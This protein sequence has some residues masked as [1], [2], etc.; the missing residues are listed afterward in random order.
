MPIKEGRG[1]KTHLARQR[2]HGRRHVAP[3]SHSLT[4]TDTDVS[5]RALISVLASPPPSSLCYSS[6]PYNP[7]ALSPPLRL[8]LPLTTAACRRR[9]C[10]A[11]PSP[12]RVTSLTTRPEPGREPRG[13]RPSTRGASVPVPQREPPK[14]LPRL[15]ASPLPLPPSMLLHSTSTVHTC[16]LSPSLLPA[17]GSQS[18]NNH[19]YR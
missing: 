3:H 9:A 17:L 19:V 6:V 16:R 15:A 13:R 2:R 14:L 10:T 4:V 18:S 11:T 7:H 12:S 5:E 1:R 8:S